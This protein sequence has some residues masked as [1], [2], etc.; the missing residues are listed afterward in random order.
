MTSTFGRVI[1]AANAGS[2]SVNRN[3]RMPKRLMRQ[4]VDKLHDDI[5]Q[6]AGGK[7]VHQ[8]NYMTRLG[9]RQ[10]QAP[11]CNRVALAV[12]DDR[13]AAKPTTRRALPSQVKSSVLIVAQAPELKFFAQ[14]IICAQD[15]S[16]PA[17]N[18]WI[19]QHRTGVHFRHHVNTSSKLGVRGA[20]MA[21]PNTRYSMSFKGEAYGTTAG[22]KATS[23][24]ATQSGTWSR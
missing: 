19:H 16:R 23:K 7:P 9:C 20:M 12:A 1:R 21:L 10:R 3:D 2:A 17:Q 6:A 18:R 4:P 22:C 24:A 13:L 15:G 8:M 14:R 11:R 5:F